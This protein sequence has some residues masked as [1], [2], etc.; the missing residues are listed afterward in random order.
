[1]VRPSPSRHGH[2]SRETAREIGDHEA[3]ESSH[4]AV[5][6]HPYWPLFD[7]EVRSPRLTLRYLDDELGAAVASVAA[8]GVHD[9]SRTPFMTP[10]TDHGSPE[11][12]RN[13]FRFWWR[14]RAETQPDHW[15]INLAA[16]EHGTVVG[17][18][19]LSADQFGVLGSFETGSWLG[20]EFQGRGLGTELR[21]ATLHLGFAGL[22]AEFATTSAFSDNAPSLAVT[23]RLG[24]E[25]EGTRRVVRRGE[26]ADL[27]GFR[28]ARAQWETIR[29]DDIEMVGVDGA[30]EILA[31]T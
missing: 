11:L 25:T 23:R 27:V 17:A 22:R 1:M 6:A 26:P 19:G 28:M 31:I 21:E 2:R 30:R 14:S 5:M 7:L 3:R 12:E 8:R 4:T 15:S 13:A 10:W 20:R 29:R 9:P 18:S 16:I 24:Y